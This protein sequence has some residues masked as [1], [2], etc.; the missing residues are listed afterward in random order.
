VTAGQPHYLAIERSGYQ[1]V[2]EELTVDG[3]EARE[4]T[5]RLK[6]LE[7]RA[8]ATP[9]PVATNAA[10]GFL[11]VETEPWTKVSVDGEPLGSTPLFKKRL[12][13]GRHELVFI[14]EGANVSEKRVVTIEPGETTKPM[15][16]FKK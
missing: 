2:E 12:A 14:N 4:V 7:G 1:R 15:L 8:K 10:P 13:A 16:S 11:S 6:A 9:L 5:I 3:G